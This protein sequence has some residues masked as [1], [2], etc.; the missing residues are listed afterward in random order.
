MCLN[1]KSQLIQT[2]ITRDNY[3]NFNKN[4]NGRNYFEK[5]KLQ[6]KHSNLETRKVISH[7]QN[8]KRFGLA[9]LEITCHLCDYFAVRQ[10]SRVENVI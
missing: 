3:F 8:H 1:T 6:P 9:V 2:K 10:L 7:I 4:L 5:S